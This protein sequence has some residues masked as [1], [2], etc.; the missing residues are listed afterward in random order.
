MIFLKGTIIRGFGEDIGGDCEIF[1]EK[2]SDRVTIELVF[3]K[4]SKTGV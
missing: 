2:D 4:M 3:E 1:F